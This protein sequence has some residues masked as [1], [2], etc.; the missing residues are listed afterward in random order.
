MP[1]IPL[2]ELGDRRAELPENREA[3]IVTVCNKGNMSI[4]GML[5]LQ[6]LGYRN[7]KSLNGGTVGW[8][9]KN[10]PTG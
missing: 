4:S 9:E 3:P 2:A 1:H 10:L 6:S 5:V 8:A 7:V